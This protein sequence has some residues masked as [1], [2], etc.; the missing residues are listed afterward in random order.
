MSWRIVSEDTSL[1]PRRN[2]TAIMIP[3]H[4]SN[5]PRP[6]GNH[7]SSYPGI[8]NGTFFQQEFKKEQLGFIVAHSRPLMGFLLRSR[9]ALYQPHGPIIPTQYVLHTLAVVHCVMG[10]TL[11]RCIKIISHRRVGNASDEC[12]LR[13]CDCCVG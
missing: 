10:G 1:F 11:G 13:L 3:H 12:Q 8:L 6:T 9:R 2:S 7:S 4:L 5:H